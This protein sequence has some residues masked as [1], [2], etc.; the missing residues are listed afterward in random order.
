LHF[1]YLNFNKRP[2]FIINSKVLHSLSGLIGIAVALFLILFPS[3]ACASHITLAW[4]SND[5]P[6]LAGYIVYYGTQ[7]RYYDYDVDVGNH[8]SVTISGLAEDVTYYFAVTAYDTQGNES[9]FSQEIVFQP[10]S[11]FSASDTSGG[12]GCFVTVA[13]ENSP[14]FGKYEI[15][16]KFSVMALVISF[17][18]AALLSRRVPLSRTKEPVP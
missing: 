18:L 1:N 14:N 9:G 3:P 5:E 17:L 10:T 7:S 11:T 15:L 16:K 6:G 8:S 4:D 2:I 13:S 12:G